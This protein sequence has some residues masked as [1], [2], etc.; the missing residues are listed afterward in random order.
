MAGTL[1]DSAV[2]VHDSM[3]NL[4]EG[5]QES[6]AD[7][8]TLKGMAQVVQ[9]YRN[10]VSENLGAPEGAQQEQ[11]PVQGT[12]TPEAGAAQVQPAM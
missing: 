1:K 5:L 2:Q 11:P 8:E 4:L 10:F 3:I 7:P 12:T 9:N 6:G